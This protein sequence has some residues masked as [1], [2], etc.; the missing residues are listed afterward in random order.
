MVRRPCPPANDVIDTGLPR[1]RTCLPCRAT[2]LGS[3][4]RCRQPVAG[5]VVHIL[6][7]SWRC[8]CCH[9]ARRATE[10]ACAHTHKSSREPGGTICSRALC[11]GLHPRPRPETLSWPILRGSK[12]G[13]SP[14]D[15]LR[16][17]FVAPRWTK[18]QWRT[19]LEM[20]RA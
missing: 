2:A 20:T 12:L 1:P 17:F 3:S 8:C 10:A 9:A 4:G 16:L 11:T 5:P 18:N 14:S 6:R 13:S 15:H 19:L 7:V